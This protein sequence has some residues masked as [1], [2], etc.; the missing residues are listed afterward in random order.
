[1]YSTTYDITFA[2]GILEKRQ[3]KAVNKTQV[4]NRPTGYNANFRPC[5]YYT[6]S[7]DNLDNPA[8]KMKVEEHYQRAHDSDFRPYHV[9]PTGDEMDLKQHD[10]LPSKSGF[11]TLRKK[12]FIASTSND[13][14]QAHAQACPRSQLGSKQ[15]MHD[16]VAMEKLMPDSD[17]PA[18]YLTENDARY[19]GKQGRWPSQSWRFHKSVGRKEPTATTRIE[20]YDPFEH[21]SRNPYRHDD[22]NSSYHNSGRLTGVTEQQYHFHEHRLHT[23]LPRENAAGLP[24]PVP[25]SERNTGYSHETTKPRFTDPMNNTK[26]DLNNCYLSPNRPDAYRCTLARYS[27]RAPQVAST[28]LSDGIGSRHVGNKEKSGFAKNHRTYRKQEETNPARFLTHY[29][30]FFIKETKPLPQTSCDRATLSLSS[31]GWPVVKASNGFTKSTRVGK[32]RVA[33]PRVHVS[34]H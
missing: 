30:Q 12:A 29:N 31:T 11:T 34:V 19:L 27:F 18:G 3:I 20:P 4:V 8:M 22:I 9:S 2:K 17:I 6:P 33:K 16:P 26:T 13:I 7:L 28:Y 1:M 32:S 5:I 24:E 23:D 25:R 14:A 10:I 15:I 21:L